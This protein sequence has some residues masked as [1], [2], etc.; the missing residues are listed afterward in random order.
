[1]Q[2][3]II[4]R[5]EGGVRAT[6]SEISRLALESLE[7]F[8]EQNL[9][10]NL[11]VT[12]VPL[13]TV[14]GFLRQAWLYVEDGPVELLRTVDVL[15]TDYIRTGRFQGDCDDA[16]IIAAAIVARKLVSFNL[17]RTKADVCAVRRPHDT[18]F[19]HVFILVTDNAGYFIIDPTAPVDADYRHW[20]T[21]TVP[22]V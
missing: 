22:I 11:L 8:P 6:C 10:M 3:K 16:A 9:L 12:G 13:R 4:P 20:E 2:E 15:I 17:S 18:S 5:N 7:A 21:L 19:S 1:M 14:D